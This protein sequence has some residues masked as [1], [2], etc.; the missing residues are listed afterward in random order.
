[1]IMKYNRYSPARNFRCLNFNGLKTFVEKNDLRFETKNNAKKICYHHGYTK[2]EKKPFAVYYLRGWRTKVSYDHVLIGI[3]EVKKLP[4][5]LYQIISCISFWNQEGEKCH[6]MN[7]QG[8]ESYSDFI[9]KCIASD[10]R[11]F[12]EPCGN[13]FITGRGHNHVWVDHNYTNKRIL[14]IHF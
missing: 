3:L 4:P 14:I 12:T 8:D 9:L 5:E 2:R 6:H 13:R 1:M 10:C 11:V 7:K